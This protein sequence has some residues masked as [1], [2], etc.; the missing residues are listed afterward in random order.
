MK[1]YLDIVSLINSD[2]YKKNQRLSWHISHAKY[3]KLAC[4]LLNLFKNLKLNKNDAKIL[5]IVK[6]DIFISLSQNRIYSF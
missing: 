1:K 6:S 2:F 4:D 3:N 5:N